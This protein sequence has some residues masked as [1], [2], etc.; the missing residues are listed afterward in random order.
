[1]ITEKREKLILK[2][3]FFSGLLFAITEFIFAIYSHSQSS[4]TDAVYDTAE[5]VFIALLLFLTPLFHRPVSE[6]HP[7]GYFQIET[8]FIIVK[9][10]MML[11]VTLGVSAEVLHS[12]LSG[13]NPVDSAL[14]SIFQCILG[15]A[16]IIIFVTMKKL[17]RNLSSPTI[18]A[19]LLGWKLDIAYSLG[20]SFAFFLSLY[21]E[22]TPLAFL[23]PYF[24]QIIAVIIIALILPESIKILLRAIRD[25][26]LFSPDKELIEEIKGLCNPIMEQYR[27]VPVF[28]DITKTGRHLWVA[29][30]F[31]IEMGS[32]A[33]HD[34][35]EALKAT[36]RTVN[37]KFHNCTCELILEP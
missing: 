1:M 33:V 12:T 25:I 24:D 37:E 31:Q 16:S 4:L 22:K 36:N 32:L 9:G 8:V 30:Y 10:I 34:L 14:V 19:E 2:M 28:Y 7:F 35:S 23:A 26:F 18:K 11:S 20:M 13:G 5:F 6:K 17:N 15:I 27:F 29:I 3:S 21:L